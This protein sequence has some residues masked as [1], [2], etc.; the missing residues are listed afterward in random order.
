MTNIEIY[1]INKVGLLQCDNHCVE[2][3][4]ADLC[5]VEFSYVKLGEIELEF[6]VDITGCSLETVKK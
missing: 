3:S 4:W 1:N 6:L 2:L 5:C